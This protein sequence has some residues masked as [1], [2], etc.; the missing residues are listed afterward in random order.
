MF[1]LQINL[2]KISIFCSNLVLKFLLRILFVIFI[3]FLFNSLSIFSFKSKILSKISH[4]F[5]KKNWFNSVNNNSESSI[6]EK[7][8]INFS[9]NSFENVLLLNRF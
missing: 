8:K 4:S 7:S 2:L 5:N 6:K 1:S 3:F 9:I